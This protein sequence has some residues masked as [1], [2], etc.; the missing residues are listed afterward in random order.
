MGVGRPP[1]RTVGKVVVGVSSGERTAR[2][3][4]SGGFHQVHGLK[5]TSRAVMTEFGFSLSARDSAP[6]IHA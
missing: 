4:K 2:D 6:R 3:W 1:F 5:G